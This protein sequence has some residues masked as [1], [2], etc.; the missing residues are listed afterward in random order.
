MLTEMQNAP[1]SFA[2]R[3]ERF[4]GEIE[5]RRAQ[6]PEE[7]DAL[8][9]LRYEAYLKE[10][11]VHLTKER[12]LRDPFDD[13]PNT[14]NVGLFHSNK[15]IS[16]LRL[17]HLTE[18]YHTSPALDVFP[19]MLKPLMEQGKRILDPNRFVA[20][21]ECARLHPELPYATVRLTIMAGTHYNVDIGTATVRQ[22][23]QA[24]YKRVF[25]AK[26]VCPPRDYPL[27]SKK[28]SL[29]VVDFANLRER[30]IERNPFFASSATERERIF[31][32]PVLQPVEAGV[33][34]Q[35]A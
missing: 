28:I 34:K 16:A 10:G 1:R 30:I 12:R 6:T 3:V 5:Y 4:L 32:A 14:V 11:A 7:I 27:L 19:D 33:R 25:F 13:V 18:P 26:E 21:Y 8:E 29:M 24:F 17:H 15:L 20:D 31:G 23:H 9:S 22:E 35:T 2:E